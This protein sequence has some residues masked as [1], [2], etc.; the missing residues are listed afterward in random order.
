MRDNYDKRDKHV[1]WIKIL[2]EEMEQKKLRGKTHYLGWGFVEG[3][4]GPVVTITRCL[5]DGCKLVGGLATNFSVEFG[6]VLYI[7]TQPG[8]RTLLWGDDFIC[9]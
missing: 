5:L 4:Y 6:V 1:G 7:K 8:E 3:A 2:F 9:K